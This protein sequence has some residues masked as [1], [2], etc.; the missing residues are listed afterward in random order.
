MFRI[1][2]NPPEA[3][4]N[5]KKVTLKYYSAT[6]ETEIEC[7][8]SDLKGV[9]A[10]DFPS[11]LIARVN[12][13]TGMLVQNASMFMI[14]RDQEA[15][16]FALTIFFGHE[17]GAWGDKLS[18]KAIYREISEILS[19][20]KLD[21]RIG[22]EYSDGEIYIFSN[23]HDTQEDTYELITETL[24]LAQELIDTAESRLLGFKWKNNYNTDEDLFTKE[25]VIPLVQKM[26]FMHVRY[27]HGPSEYGRDI[28][29]SEPDKLGNIRRLAAQV[30]AGDIK[31]GANSLIDTIIAQIDDAFSMPVQGPGQSKTYHI[32]DMLI[33]SSGKIS[34]NAIKKINSKIDQR[35]SGSVFFIDRDDLDWLIK[36]HWPL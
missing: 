30:K 25:L 12:V 16:R 10:S 35:L 14:H 6:I 21:G 31:G 2:E 5:N 19:K 28:L 11:L 36:K 22:I 29:F 17:P 1:T 18:N 24:V 8:L 33:I 3:Y 9:K 4:I 7:N 20:K 13:D 23:F 32:S 27:N 15:E 26:G 34:E